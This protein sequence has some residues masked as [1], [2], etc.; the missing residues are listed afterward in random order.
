MEVDIARS[1]G[2]GT[3]VK[4]FII[5]IWQGSKYASELWMSE[6]KHFFEILKYSKQVE[7]WYL[8]YLMWKKLRPISEENKLRNIWKHKPF[9][10]N[11]NSSI[12][13][14]GAFSPHT[15][16]LYSFLRFSYE[17][18]LPVALFL[19]VINFTCQTFCFLYH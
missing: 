7:G 17:L 3:P 2:K 5:D 6:K 16:S 19:Q 15:L 10:I 14:P 18:L 1:F 8:Y 12:I 13:F 11:S 9:F 4:S